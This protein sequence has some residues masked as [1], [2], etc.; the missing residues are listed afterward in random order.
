MLDLLDHIWIGLPVSYAVA[1]G[2]LVTGYRR[3]GVP[4]ERRLPR[5]LLA[6][7]P[8]MLVVMLVWDCIVEYVES[9]INIKGTPFIGLNILL[10]IVFLLSASALIGA[11]LARRN[12]ALVHERG[13]VLLE[14]TQRNPSV[15]EPDALT[16]AGQPI[17]LLDETKHFKI[18][19][20]TGTGKS[21][22]IRELLTGALRRGDRAVIAD[23]DGGYLQ[24]YYD[25]GRGDVILNP[26]DPRAARW[27]LFAEI[28]L[29][30]DADQ[31]ARSFIP[32]CDGENRIW[33][34]FAQT[35]VSSILR[36]L[37][38]IEQ[39]DLGRLYSLLVPSSEQDLDDLR[40]LL[41]GTPAA[42]FLGKKGGRF[43]E[44]VQSTT[45]QHMSAI[46]HLGRQSGGDALSV[47]RW[48]REGRGV[49][50]LPYRPNEIA[51]LKNSI[52]TWM[53]L[54]IFEAMSAPEGDQRIWFV[55]DELDALGA[56][57]GLKDALTR[58]R[59][60]GGRCILGFQSIA[61]VRGSYGDAAS[62]SIVENC[63]NTVILHCS[64]SEYG[65]TA[66]FASRLIGKR[67]IVRQQ[68][69]TSRS[70]D[71]LF[72]KTHTVSDHLFTEDAVMASEIEQLP[73]LSGFM[74]LASW[75]Y[76]QRVNLVRNP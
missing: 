36:Q 41:E 16:L 70:S 39:H 6:G 15:A 20:T 73:D 5:A 37:H 31:L 63:G 11:M 75:P 27:D 71:H 7:V 32:D 74:K 12:P 55:I 69:S 26:F 1:V 33:C 61:Q 59:K 44:S 21:T 45:I 52:S 48:I 29:P 3:G 46:E 19:G 8:V 72:K 58:L 49:L 10:G 13:T 9:G 42:P 4:A 30:Q 23:P 18:V 60:F 17:P 67:Q 38:R 51:T 24:R 62:Q 50:F 2:G 65:G 68:R 66:E 54:A 64:A 14:E 56:I 43:L 34:G 35:Y 22:A 40:D 28:I 76:W 25:P 47:R 57:D 53:R